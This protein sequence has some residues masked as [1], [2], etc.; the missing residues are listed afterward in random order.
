M[1]GDSEATSE[2]TPS[3]CI[4]S[5][6]DLTSQSRLEYMS[7]GSSVFVRES[8]SDPPFEEASPFGRCLREI[9]LLDDWLIHNFPV[10]MSDE[11]FCRL[12]LTFRFLMMCPLG[13]ATKGKSVLLGAC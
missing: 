1:S 5:D 9:V 4:G 11:V 10:D 7:E 12:R 13:R 8:A 3:V 6:N 2:L